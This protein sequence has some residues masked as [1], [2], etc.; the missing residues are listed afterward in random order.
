MEQKIVWWKNDKALGFGKF[1]LEE[2]ERGREREGRDTWQLGERRRAWL[3]MTPEREGR[4][5]G[6]EE[7]ERGKGG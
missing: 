1:G 3:P 4:E 6:K 7:S 2:G 5:G